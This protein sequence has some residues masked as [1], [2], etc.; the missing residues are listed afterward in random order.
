MRI[1]EKKPLMIAKR[2]H[3]HHT[4]ENLGFSRRAVLVIILFSGI[5][6]LG[7]GKLVDDNFPAL[8]FTLFILLFL[9]YLSV[10]IHYSSITKGK[11]Y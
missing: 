5:A 8:S 9:C 11:W 6:F 1:I 3:I 4:L 7:I 2:D 10:R